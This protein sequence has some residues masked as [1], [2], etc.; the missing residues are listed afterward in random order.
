MF[1]DGYHDNMKYKN[2]P[3]KLLP[4]IPNKIDE[5]TSCID[6]EYKNKYSRSICMLYD[7][8]LS[9]KI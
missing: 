9:D 6:F 3:A 7:K 2:Q 8:Y 4:F 5:Q 1:R